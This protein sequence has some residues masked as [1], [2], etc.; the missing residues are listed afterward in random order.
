MIHGSQTLHHHW[1][2]GPADAGNYHD[3]HRVGRRGQV[4][5][6]VECRLGIIVNYCPNGLEHHRVLRAAMS[7]AFE[8]AKQIGKRWGRAHD[9]EI[10][11]SRDAWKTRPIV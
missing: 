10:G 11:E 1:K 9:L 6:L 4:V 8:V 5:N 3:Q 2:C 7:A